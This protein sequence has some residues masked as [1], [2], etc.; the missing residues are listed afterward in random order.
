MPRIRPEHLVKTL[1][2]A[3]VPIY[4]ISG[5]EPLLMQEACDAVRRAAHQSGFSERE[6]YRSDSTLDWHH[7]RQTVNSLSLFSEKKIIEVHIKN[8]KV[9]EAGSS[10][11][12]EYCNDP[13]RDTVLLLIFPKLNKKNQS[14]PWALAAEAC[15]HSVTVWPVDPQQLD[16]WVA[17]RLHR[18]GL[19]ATEP[20]IELLCLKTEGNLL[21]AAQEIEK[22]K[23]LANEGLIDVDLMRAVVMD[24]ARYNVFS[25]V[26]KALAGNSRAAMEN[27]Q[28]L[29]GEGATPLS[30]LG[31]LT[32]ELRVLRN[33]KESMENGENFDLAARKN[34]VWNNRK[35]LVRKAVQNHSLQGLQ[36]LLR[37]AAQADRTVKGMSQGDEWSILLDIV[38]TLSGAQCFSKKTRKMGLTL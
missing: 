14:A 6:V 18:A 7:L 17:A 29:Q 33:V 34:G 35:A 2:S 22:L 13:P 28:G 32:R 36:M 10:M 19:Q 21:A 38:L 1:Q 8:G 30:I 3:L 26:D 9:D 11:L 31:M 20:A 16:S 15:G 27:L 25:L 23:L 37:S 12:Q 24:S 4:L 5:D